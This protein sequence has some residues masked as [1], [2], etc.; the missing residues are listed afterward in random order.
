MNKPRYIS[1]KEFRDEGYLQEVNRQ[2]LHP[3]GL[4]LEVQRDEESGEVSFGRVWDYR[5]D[6]EG[7]QYSGFNKQDNWKAENVWRHWVK[8]ATVRMGKF[9]WVIQPLKKE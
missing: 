4:A 7:I 9:G 5:D 3:L 6:P 2:F 1:A 8:K